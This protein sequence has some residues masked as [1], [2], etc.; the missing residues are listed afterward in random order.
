MPKFDKSTGYR[1]RSGNGP[2][3]F[4][5][6]GG[7]PAQSGFGEAFSTA[8]GELGPGKT[9]EYKG[10]SF[11]TD[12]ADGKDMR[13]PSNEVTSVDSNK[14]LTDIST[15]NNDKITAPDVK[16][17]ETKSEIKVVT[18]PP[19]G[20]KVTGKGDDSKAGVSDVGAITK[21][22]AKKKGSWFKRTMD[23]LGKFQQS[24]GGKA[25]SEGLMDLGSSKTFQGKGA[26]SFNDLQKERQATKHNQE[27]KEKQIKLN[28]ETQALA[29]NRNESEEK[30]KQKVH[31]TK[32][33]DEQVA[34]NV[35]TQTMNNERKKQ[36]IDATNRKNSGD[37]DL[38]STDPFSTGSYED[39]LNV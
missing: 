17:K 14:M 22:D 10:K 25:L 21:D 16:P 12:R 35:E 39:G 30:R 2:L 32:Y 38:A 31:D 27:T 5:E 18:P 26:R 1:M 33:S 8:A 23:K 6:M 13:K 15:S 4:K 11:S 7:S 24:E 9:F 37:G 29:A 20:D 34:L 3:P 36:L 19:G 28:E